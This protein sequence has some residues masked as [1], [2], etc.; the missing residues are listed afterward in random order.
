MKPTVHLE[1][2]QKWSV[3]Q[4]S[5]HFTSSCQ[6]YTCSFKSSVGPDILISISGECWSSRPA[7]LMISLSSDRSRWSFLFFIN[8]TSIGWSFELTPDD[9]NKL[10]YLFSQSLTWIKLWVY[11]I[12]IVG[13]WFWNVLSPCFSESFLRVLNTYLLLRS[14]KDH[15]GP[16][17]HERS[18]CSPS[19]HIKE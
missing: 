2:R 19:L 4:P 9:M 1:T 5:L 6:Y 18:L 15:Q 7:A 13:F 17:L 8:L 14:P 11:E 10:R 12:W 3:F 16:H